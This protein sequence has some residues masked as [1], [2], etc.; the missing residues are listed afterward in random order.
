MYVGMIE[1]R[2]LK[3]LLKNFHENYSDLFK[4]QHGKRRVVWI[5][6]SGKALVFV[7][8]V[9]GSNPRANHIPSVYRLSLVE[10]WILV[11]S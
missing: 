4:K 9:L 3:I 6:Q 2:S 11:K 7:R 10:M 5:A 1:T 8:E